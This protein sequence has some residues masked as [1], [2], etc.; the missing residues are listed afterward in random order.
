[1]LVFN[2][3]IFN[4]VNIYLKEYYK[5]RGNLIIGNQLYL[6]YKYD[7]SSLSFSKENT[8]EYIDK[9]LNIINNLSLDCLVVKAL[10]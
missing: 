2:I 10:F 6:H 3:F 5:V 9:E 8:S 1:M 4:K 7:S